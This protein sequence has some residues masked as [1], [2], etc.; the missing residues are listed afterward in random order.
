MKGKKSMMNNPD[1]IWMVEFYKTP[2]E[3]VTVKFLPGLDK[4]HVEVEKEILLDYPK[5]IIRKCVL[6]KDFK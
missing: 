5:A 6:L 2:N 4:S 3:H 1:N